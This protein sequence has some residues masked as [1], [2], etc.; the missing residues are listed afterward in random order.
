MSFSRCHNIAD[1]RAR[2]AKR[3]PR[4]IFDYIDGGADD[5]RALHRNSSA[6]DDYELLPSVLTDVSAPSSKTTLFGRD[7]PWPVMLSPTGL[8]RMFHPEAELAVARAAVEQGIPYCLS[9]LGTTT[10]E[11]FARVLPTPKLFQIYIFKD[12]GLTAEFVTRARVSG[13]DGLVL[14]VDTVVAGNRE[15]D[16]VN[17]FSLPPRLSARSMLS[18]ALHPGWSL[19]VL[20]GRKF[21]FVNVSHRGG[22]VA[23]GSTSLFQYLGSQFDRSLVWKDLEWLATMWNGPLAVKGVMT[24]AD[25]SHAADCGATTVMISNHGGRQLDEAPA[26]VD[27]IAPIADAV[28]GR[29][30]IICDGGIRRGSHIVKA[31]ALG[32]DACAIG[33]PYLYGLAAGGQPGVARALQILREEY[34]RT[35]ALSGASGSV[36]LSRDMV[37]KIGAGC[38]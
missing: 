1:L 5:E 18:F 38:S 11:E 30:Q 36:S 37:R 3:L 23:S 17:G 9:T 15:R 29:M 34:D 26:P 13:Y 33:R 24:P 22:S 2:A 12:R 10:I 8:T 14:T 28:G 6:F 16:R 27:Q 21:D 35:L 4:P 19:P 7:I 20:F 25:A 32:A 31:L